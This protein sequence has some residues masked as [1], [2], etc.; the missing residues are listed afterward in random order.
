M[1]SNRPPAARVATSPTLGDRLA[2]L[3]LIR[4][5]LQSNLSGSGAGSPH[6]FPVRF[7]RSIG[8][9]GPDSPRVQSNRPP[10]APVAASPVRFARPIG[11]L[12]VIRHGGTRTVRL[13]RGRLPA[14]G[15][16]L[17]SLGLTRHRRRQLRALGYFRRRLR[18]YFPSVLQW[19]DR[20]VL[21][22]LSHHDR[23]PRERE[24]DA[25]RDRK[26]SA[27]M[28]IGS[29]ENLRKIGRSARW[30]RRG[31]IWRTG[32][33]G[34]VAGPA[35]GAPLARFPLVRT[36]QTPNLVGPAAR[37]LETYLLRPDRD[38]P[39]RT[40]PARR[41]SAPLDRLP[42]RPTWPRP[43]R[44]PDRARSPHA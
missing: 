40:G 35:A 42:S 28:R 12:R 39:R 34:A 11:F 43:A 9:L 10:P 1:Q 32:E 33:G 18:R 25:E 27:G 17:A 19:G 3:R 13:W 16:R 38:D 7:G 36:E 21:R 2:S 44:S 20:A 29:R 37:G 24:H 5:R 30:P 8:F 41:P 4:R 14:S 22:V 31:Q 23:G 15:D 26:R 6:V